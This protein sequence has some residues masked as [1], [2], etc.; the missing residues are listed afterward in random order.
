[1]LKK[2]FF[3]TLLPLLLTTFVQANGSRL[4][5]E[6]RG[7]LFFCMEDKKFLS[8]G[9]EAAFCEKFE[10]VKDSYKK[11][12]TIGFLGVETGYQ[13]SDR[14]SIRLGSYMGCGSIEYAAEV[15]ESKLVL[16]W[17]K[18]S[19]KALRDQL[20]AIQ[21]LDICDVEKRAKLGKPELL[22]SLQCN[23][24]LLLETR[25]EF[26]KSSSVNLEA[27]LGVGVAIWTAVSR[28][29]GLVSRDNR[30]FLAKNIHTSL[31]SDFSAG[32]VVIGDVCLEWKVTH[33]SSLRASLGYSF[34]SKPG[35][36]LPALG[37]EEMLRLELGSVHGLL[38]SAGINFAF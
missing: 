1:M 2:L 34:L 19:N 20:R 27:G 38:L 28:L 3:L 15:R 8:A 36:D 29:H 24:P 33:S 13:A 32:P 31:R 10:A 37:R 23:L 16:D 22:L 11:S 5:F 6:T 26:Y 18:V 12:S 25:Y 17:P 30:N 9:N 4:S 14:L 35:I 21:G 7:L